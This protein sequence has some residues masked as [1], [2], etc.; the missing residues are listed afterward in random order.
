ME[1]IKGDLGMLPG[2][3]YLVALIAAV[4]AMWRWDMRRMRKAR[5]EAELMKQHMSFI[6]GN[7]RKS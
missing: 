4:L 1:T 5:R 3:M 7:G 6:N 2:V